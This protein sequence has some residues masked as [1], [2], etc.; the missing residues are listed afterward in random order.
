MPNIGQMDL[1]LGDIFTFIMCQA[2]RS[3]TEQISVCFCYSIFCICTCER[4]LLEAN[5]SISSDFC[6]NINFSADSKCQIFVEV[7]HTCSWL[8]VLGNLLDHDFSV[9]VLKQHNA[10]L[11]AHA[12]Q[13]YKKEV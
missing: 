13:E 3:S 4:L 10:K 6:L 9:F 7:F 1:F 5:K 2:Q 12:S 11:H 8:F